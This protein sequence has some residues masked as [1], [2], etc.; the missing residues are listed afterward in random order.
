M[1]NIAEMSLDELK[2]FQRES[3]IGHAAME[4]HRKSYESGNKS[5]LLRVLNYC[6]L[7]NIAIPIW[8]AIAISEGISDLNNGLIDDANEL[9]GVDPKARKE[10]KEAWVIQ[11]DTDRVINALFRLRFEGR[12]M[13][14]DDSLDQVAK[15]LGLPRRRVEQIY[16]IYGN[17]VKDIPIDDPNRGR[18]PKRQSTIVA[19][20]ARWLKDTENQKDV[21]D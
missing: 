9:F 4:L 19:E 21:S 7:A 13:A 12:S 1:I 5:E 14:A 20:P 16:K 15:D 10:K 11:E 8:C 3:L 2:A 18:W 17:K 6:C